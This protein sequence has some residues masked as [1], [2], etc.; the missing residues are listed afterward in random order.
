VTGTNVAPNHGWRHRFMTVGMEA[1]I[2]PRILDALEGH[3]PRTVGDD[4]G[5]VTVKVRAMAIAKLP[6][7][8]V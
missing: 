5:D 6:R 7:Y 3:K 2:A 8:D 4:Y 1:D